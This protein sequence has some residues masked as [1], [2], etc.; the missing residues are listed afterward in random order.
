MLIFESASKIAHKK[1][2]LDNKPC[3]MALKIE[4]L[5]RK[6]AIQETKS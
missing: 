4:T 1:E 3:K 6:E 5:G 2:R